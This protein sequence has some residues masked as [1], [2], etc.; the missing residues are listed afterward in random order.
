MIVLKPGVY[1]DKIPSAVLLRDIATESDRT[2]DEEHSP[3][4]E[5]IALGDFEDRDVAQ[6]AEPLTELLKTGWLV[7]ADSNL[8]PVVASSL[9][10]LDRRFAWA[11]DVDCERTAFI[12]ATHASRRRMLRSMGQYPALPETVA[13]RVRLAGNTP[14]DILVLGDDDLLSPALAKAGHRVTVIEADPFLVKFLKHKAKR[15]HLEIDVH[16]W[17]MR[18]PMPEKLL[19]RF[20]VAFSDPM[21]GP[22]CLGLFMDRAFSGL[23]LGGTLWMCVNNPAARVFDV[24]RRQTKAALL[25]HYT[26]F[27]HYYSAFMTVA[28]YVSDM[29][30]LEKLEPTKAVLAPSDRFLGSGLFDEVK[31]GMRASSRFVLRDINLKYAQ[32]SHVRAVMEEAKTQAGIG[33]CEEVFHWNEKHRTYAAI[34]DGGRVLWVNVLEEPSSVHM[35]ISPPDE[36]IERCFENALMSVYMKEGVQPATKRMRNPMATELP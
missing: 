33:I 8:D 17:D 7:H 4:L 34:L 10:Q 18:T 36:K 24:H 29:Y 20:D 6:L 27:N 22:A 1:I 5:K 15:E 21:S 2:V 35:M 9:L 11:G 31:Y 3:Q 23:K 16:R 30:G 28:A 19:G 14:L 26:D 25:T 12:R 32:L 13:R